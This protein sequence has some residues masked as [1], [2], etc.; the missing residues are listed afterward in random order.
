MLTSWAHSAQKN[1]VY[2]PAYKPPFPFPSRAN[3]SPLEREHLEFIKQVKGIPIN[4][5]FINSLSKIPAYAKLLQDLVDTRQQLKKNSKVILSEQSSRVV[6]GELPKKMGDPGRLTFPC[7]FG[8]NLKTYDLADSGASINLMPYSFY[9]KLNIQKMKTTKMTI[10]M[11]NRSVTQ[12][13]GI[14][15]DILV[16]NGRFIFPVDFVILDMKEDANVPIILGR[17][18]LNTVGA[19]V[20]VREVFN[21]DEDNELEEL[22]KLMEEIKT[23]NQVKRTK[24][25][26]SVSFLVEVIA[27]TKPTSWV[28]K[29][30]DDMSSDEEEVTSKVTSPVVKEEEDIMKFKNDEKLKTQG[31][32][33]KLDGNEVKAKKENSK[34]AYI[35]R[36]Q[37]YKRRFKEKKI[38]VVDSFEDST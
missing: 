7:E 16:K 31:I 22:E 18:F 11:A 8:N 35:R 2:V 37:S 27:Y 14:V 36:V 9:Q 26:A 15:E 32:K 1:Y 25:R 23:L 6:L 12:L 10:H 3:L 17:P 20:D 19:L 5:P 28:S 30:S 33:H 13:R 24:P 21:I 4:T 38:L 34:K 29:E